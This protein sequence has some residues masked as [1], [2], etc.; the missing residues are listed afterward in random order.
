MN[1]INNIR[2]YTPIGECG[3][4]PSCYKVGNKV[5]NICPIDVKTEEV[6][7]YPNGLSVKV[8]SHVPEITYEIFNPNK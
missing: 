2:N 3:F 1:S 4:M 6:I 8:T 5:T 7:F